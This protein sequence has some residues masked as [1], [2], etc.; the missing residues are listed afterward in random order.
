ME[1]QRERQRLLKEILQGL[2]L[3]QTNLSLLNG[4]MA[5]VVQ[6]QRSNFSNVSKVW[7]EFVAEQA[8]P[9]EEERL[10]QQQ[11]QQQQSLQDQQQ[12]QNTK[13]EQQAT[14]TAPATATKSTRKKR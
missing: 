3:A 12:Q 11:Q 1:F 5:G 7:N 13:A 6:V 14:L 2:E 10:R 9:F 4:E 8:R